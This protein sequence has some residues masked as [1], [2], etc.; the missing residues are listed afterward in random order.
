MKNKYAALF[1]LYHPKEE[2]IC[3]IKKIF[4][5]FDIVYV[6]DN[7]EEIGRKNK[8][9]QKDNIEYYGF[10]ENK[11]LSEPY[12]FILS[13]AMITNVDW[14]FLYDQDSL[15]TETAID[16]MKECVENGI[17]DDI[18]IVAPTIQYFDIP[19]M[20][21]STKYEK[22]AINSGSML[23]VKLIQEKKLLYDENLFLDKVD[24]DF[25]K[26]IEAKN[27]RILRLGDVILQ[28]E[29]GV[30]YN[31]QMIHSPLRN[32]YRHKNRLYYNRKYYNGITGWWISIIQTLGEIK[33]ILK[34]GVDV[35]ENLRMM[36]KAQKDYR[37]KKWGKI[38]NI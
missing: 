31:G 18:V 7:T 3:N 1:I 37:A 5:L 25:C 17:N 11:G 27:L 28:Q 33:H 26:Q 30:L 16:K 15:I 9:F 2:E 4:G 29:L 38:E 34:S 23:N 14:L 12:N 10:G 21:L 13:K 35:K 36:R 8:E 20:D 24:H 22:F 19:P 6:Y 32:Y